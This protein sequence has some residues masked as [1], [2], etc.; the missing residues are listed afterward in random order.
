MM[1]FSAILANVIG[2]QTFLTAQ[3][4]RLIFS[5]GA[6]AVVVTT[7]P[8]LVFGKEQHYE[9]LAASKFRFLQIFSQVLSGTVTS[10]CLDAAHTATSS[11]AYDC[12]CCGVLFILVCLRTIYIVFHHFRW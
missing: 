11:K 2:A 5:I 10:N 3:P 8:T 1:G 6:V 7:I 9:R 12:Y 4:Y